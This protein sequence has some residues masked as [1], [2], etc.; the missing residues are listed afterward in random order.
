[1]ERPTGPLPPIPNGVEGIVKGEDVLDALV[2]TPQQ[3]QAPPPGIQPNDAIT[4]V[5]GM[6]DR[7]NSEVRLPSL[8]SSTESTVASS[9]AITSSPRDEEQI[10]FSM[11]P[12]DYKIGPAI[13]FG[14][15][16]IVYHTTYS[17]LQRIVAV[18]MIDLD[19][20][21][22]NQIDELRREIQVM[23][24]CKHSNLLKIHASFV[25]ESKLW[26]VTPYLSGGSCLDIM[27]TGFRD[28]LD[29]SSIATILLQ[30][31]QG[32]EYLHR[33]GHI[34]RD[35]KAGNL[36]MDADGGVQLADFGVSSCLTEDVDRRGVRKTFVGTPCW[37][38][39]EVMEMTR[40][41]DAKADIWSFGITA[42]ELAYGH[43][44]FSKYPPMKVIY[45]T[46]SSAPP[47]LDRKR[48][49]NK[50]S[51]TLKEMIDSCLQRDP[52]KRYP[53]DARIDDIS[54]LGQRQR[55]C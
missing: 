36:L 12:D 14:S 28:G 40:G 10:A 48:S 9:M 23:T 16:A 31:L 15:S 42:L 34:H 52:S 5:V 47:A 26:I 7:R 30:A 54:F 1:M 51:R 21:E 13:G 8:A 32:L 2:L 41:Y 33:N 53:T 3:Q 6:D 24:L 49:K 25:H 18:K 44:P 45:L 22:R 43:A 55:F 11:N 39:P 29:E 17:P 35:V 19:H 27:K 37:M 20:F 46:L 50:Y 38:A 4:E